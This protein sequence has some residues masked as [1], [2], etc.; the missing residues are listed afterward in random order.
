MATTACPFLLCTICTVSAFYSVRL[1]LCSFITV[2]NFN[3]ASVICCDRLKLC[4]TVTCPFSYVSDCNFRVSVVYWVVLTLCP[5][6]I[7]SN[8]HYVILQPLRVRSLLCTIDTVPF[9]T[10]ACPFSNVSNLHCVRFLLWPISIVCRLFVVSDWRCVQLLRFRLFMCPIATAVCPFSIV[11]D[12][13]CV[14]L[15]L[16]CVRF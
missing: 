2:S 14:R 13:L 15:Q 4:L 7:V 6:D 1:A 8:L 10:T 12:W 16:P 5:N 11:S 9:A 3:R